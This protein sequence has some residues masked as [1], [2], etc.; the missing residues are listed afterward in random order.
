MFSERTEGRILPKN[1]IT[2]CKTCHQDLHAKYTQETFPIQG[3]LTKTKHAT[4][5]GI[6]KSQLR[7]SGWK[8]TETFGY[9][10]KFRREIVL[11]LPKTHSNNAIAICCGAKQIIQP[12]SIGYVKRHVAAGD[13]QQIKGKYSQ[14]K[15]PTG[16]LFGIRNTE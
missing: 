4:E 14:K 12:C 9:E 1:L 3:A 5:I 8:F 7:K 6:I 10:T 11:N 16:K 15:I 13:Y 2:L